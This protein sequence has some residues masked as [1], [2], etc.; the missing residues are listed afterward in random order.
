MSG[1]SMWECR[2]ECGNTTVVY[3]GHF[4]D[5]HT[6]SCGCHKK[7]V[8]T[9]HGQ[10]GTKLY[11]TWQNI[12]QR[13]TNP[14]HP[15][16]KYWGGRGITISNEYREFINFY[17]DMGKSFDKHVEEHG[18]RQTTIDRVDNNKGYERGNLRWAT[19]TEQ[20]YNRRWGKLSI[21]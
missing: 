2:C 19:P 15:E 18:G 17:R 1:R 14:S 11:L 13:T 6:K 4:R 12:V 10:S 9:K 3:L 21:H 7:E 5:G 20:N 8:N 16:Y